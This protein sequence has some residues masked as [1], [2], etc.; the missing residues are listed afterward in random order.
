MAQDGSLACIEWLGECPIEDDDIELVVDLEGGSIALPLITYGSPLGLVE[1][2]LE[3]STNDGSVL[4]PLT[5]GDL[6]NVLKGKDRGIVRAV[7]GL[8]FEGVNTKYVFHCNCIIYIY[9]LPLQ[10]DL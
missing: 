8:M 5:D 3:S 10:N 6:P 1:I 7:D 9:Y 4:D 2:R